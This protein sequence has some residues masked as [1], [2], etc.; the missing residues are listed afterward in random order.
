[1]IIVT[2][3]AKCRGEMAH[4]IGRLKVCLLNRLRMTP[5]IMAPIDFGW[6]CIDFQSGVRAVCL[7]NQLRMTP[8]IM[9]PIVFGWKCID[10]QKV[11]LERSTNQ[12]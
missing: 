4:I 2:N 5:S 9:A 3:V 6:K 1:M 7:L 12:S 8:S 11:V 10:F